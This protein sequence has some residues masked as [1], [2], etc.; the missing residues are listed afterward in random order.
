[1]PDYIQWRNKNSYRSFPIADDASW[2]TVSGLTIPSD[3][4]LDAMIT[5]LDTEDR[6]WV[7]SIDFNEGKVVVSTDLG[8]VAAAEISQGQILEFFDSYGR[9]LGIIVPADK[10]FT[11]AGSLFFDNQA[12]PLASDAVSPQLQKGLRGFILPD[13]TVV[14]GDVVFEGVNGIKVTAEIDVDGVETLRFDALYEGDPDPPCLELPPPVKCVKVSQ[15][16]SGGVFAIAVDGNTINIGAPYELEDLC[17]VKKEKKLP[18]EGGGMPRGKRWKD[19]LDAL[20]D[21]QPEPQC[22]PPVSVPPTTICERDMFVN[23]T[24]S[25]YG[26]ATLEEPGVPAFDGYI[27]LPERPQQGIKLFIR[28]LTT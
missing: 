4:F 2:T 3:I 28:G 12:L 17:R 11:L 1:M 27:T 9:Q 21:P 8:E 15:T 22:D 20:C 26:I 7:S 25:L 13:G 6:V 18:D 10:F 24:S 16:G 5:P 23:P 19:A 14:A